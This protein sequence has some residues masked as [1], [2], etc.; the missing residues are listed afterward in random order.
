VVTFHKLAPKLTRVEVLFDWQPRGIVEK[1]GSG[2]RVHKR[3]AKTDL[4]RFKAFVEMRGEETGGWPGRIK[5]GEATSQARN[6]RNKKADPVPTEA[7]Q[8]SEEDEQKAQGETNGKGDD[9]SGR[10]AAREE[11]K[12]HREE[13]AKQKK[14]AS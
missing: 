13:R 11:R 3:A 7:Q 10:D 1:I 9:D 8:H 14:E 12:R 4:Q 5:D 6:K 2:L